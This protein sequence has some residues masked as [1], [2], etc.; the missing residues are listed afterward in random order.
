MRTPQLPAALEQHHGALL[1]AGA[2]RVVSRN[3]QPLPEPVE[4]GRRRPAP[5]RQPRGEL[6]E[7]AHAGRRRHHLA[8]G[9]DPSGRYQWRGKSQFPHPYKATLSPFIGITNAIL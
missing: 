6:H 7:R 2:E 3:P 4:L 5:V 9:P 1:A 8:V